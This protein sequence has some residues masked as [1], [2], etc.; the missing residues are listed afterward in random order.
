MHVYVETVLLMTNGNNDNNDNN[1]NN[2]NNNNNI[3]N[4]RYLTAF[5]NNDEKTI[6]EC[7]SWPLTFIGDGNS[8]IIDSFPVKPS[9]LKKSM[10]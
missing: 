1:K 4:L 5:N 6:N 8:T 3:I 10:G 2:G 7:V 9:E